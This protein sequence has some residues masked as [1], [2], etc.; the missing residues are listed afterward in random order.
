VEAVAVP[1]EAI[2]RLRYVAVVLAAVVLPLIATAGDVIL[3][4]FALHFPGVGHSEWTSE[5][6]VTN[7]GPQTLRVTLGGV[8]YGR[9]VS[10]H[11][12][13]P[14]VV[15]W[16]IPAYS[17]A[18]W[19]ASA[20]WL[21]LGCPELALGGLTLHGD[22][23]LVVTSRLVNAAPVTY[24]A[25]PLAG[26]SQE[27]PGIPVEDLPVAGSTYLLPAIGWPAIPCGPPRFDN[28]LRVVNPGEEAMTLT[29]QL[30]QPGS[31]GMLKVNGVDLEVPYT[32]KFEA[33]SWNQVRV[34][35]PAPVVGTA[36]CL[37]PAF[38]DLFF[39]VSAPVAVYVSVI[40]RATQDPRSVLPIKLAGPVHP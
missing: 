26:V 10:T 24:E 32:L 5:V 31:Q 34:G 35:P 18:P 40:D 22:G 14:P 19:F 27:I 3:P 36:A 7:P 28:Y 16:D 13:L 25:V 8:Y 17:S 12:C 9:Q 2:M 15:P 37:P 30:D 20:I 23:P 4:T 6:Y 29:L 1:S 33:R 11:P 39:T 38:H 21:D